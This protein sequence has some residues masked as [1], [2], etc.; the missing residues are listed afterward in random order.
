MIHSNE[1]DMIPLFL[2]GIPIIGGNID[3]FTL[4]ELHASLV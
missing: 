4:C 3:T 2:H 1:S